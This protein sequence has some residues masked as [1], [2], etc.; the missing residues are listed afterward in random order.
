MAEELIEETQFE[1]DIRKE[2]AEL[3]QSVEGLNQKVNNQN[4]PIIG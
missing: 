3:K 1:Q 4:P 2:L